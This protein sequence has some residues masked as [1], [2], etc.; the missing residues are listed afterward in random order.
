[1]NREFKIIQ[2]TF[3]K[4]FSFYVIDS[5][6]HTIIENY[7]Q[8]E[9]S[10]YY[11]HKN[12][13]WKCDY[14]PQIDDLLKFRDE[15]LVISLFT[16]ELFPSHKKIHLD[17]T[18]YWFTTN[19]H[20]I[21]YQYS[22]S[23]PKKDRVIVYNSD[24]G[25]QTTYENKNVVDIFKDTSEDIV[26]SVGSNVSLSLIFYHHLRGRLTN[27]HLVESYKNIFSAGRYD[28]EVY[29]V[30]YINRNIYFYDK[31]GEYIVHYV[32]YPYILKFYHIRNY[33][34]TLMY[35]KNEIM[36]IP[37]VSL[38]NVL[39]GIFD[40]CI[41]VNYSCDVEPFLSEDE[42]H[43]LYLIEVDEDYYL[44]CTQLY[45][46]NLSFLRKIQNLAYTSIYYSN[47][48]VKLTTRYGCI[49]EFDLNEER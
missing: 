10:L 11:K 35:L 3:K 30:Q 17:T 5:Y 9:Q 44:C 12:K 46:G 28:K 43:L 13:Y 29:Y 49:I 26:F 23:Y 27:I 47:G 18:G 42:L 19:K 20:I 8:G 2:E 33:T 32:R 36:V 37:Y 1:M 38:K 4:Y 39:N 31:N 22:M 25:I 41:T 7:V 16:A 24:F 21:Y 40:E 45:K 14:A 15:V 6:I 48:K 34:Y